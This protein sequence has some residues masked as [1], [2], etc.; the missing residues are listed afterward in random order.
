LKHP[1]NLSPSY[2]GTKKKMNYENPYQEAQVQF[3]QSNFPGDQSNLSLIKEEDFNNSRGKK[4]LSGQG[5]PEIP[6]I[7]LRDSGVKQQLFTGNQ[8]MKMTKYS[9][10]TGRA[11][12]KTNKTYN[13]LGSKPPVKLP[14][15]KSA[16]L[17]HP[18]EGLNLQRKAT[19]KQQ[20]AFV[21]NVKMC[22]LCGSKHAPGE[23]HRAKQ[24]SQFSTRRGVAKVGF[25]GGY[26]AMPPDL[27]RGVGLKKNST[28]SKQG[29]N[30]G[31]SNSQGRSF[32]MKNRLK[33]NNMAGKYQRSNAHNNSQQPI[34]TNAE[35]NSVT[36]GK[37]PVNRKL[38][39]S[40]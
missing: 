13:S 34:R 28:S 24:A 23:P 1:A 25:G 17:K 19:V 4:H 3:G 29:M 39:Q 8:I 11:S 5:K 16:Y 10:N 21:T 36:F 38:R 32:P 6:G 7:H 12:K 20:M 18:G 27:R 37:P 33:A 9:Q 14:N 31:V 15:L 26:V 22:G 2:R 30:K 35:M 40:E